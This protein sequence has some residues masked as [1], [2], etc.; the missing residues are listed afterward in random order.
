MQKVLPQIRV[1]CQVIR[2]DGSVAHETMVAEFINMLWAGEFIRMAR[3]YHDGTI[4]VCGRGT[5]IRYE[6]VPRKI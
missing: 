2:E 5:K 4:G 1:Y 3:Q 6:E